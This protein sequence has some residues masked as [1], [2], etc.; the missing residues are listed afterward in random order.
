MITVLQ[1]DRCGNEPASSELADAE[2]TTSDEITDRL[3]RLEI[4]HEGGEHA[5]GVGCKAAVP[6]SES[7]DKQCDDVEGDA[8][9][10]T[11]RTTN[12]RMSNSPT[13][14]DGTEAP[15]VVDVLT[16][17]QHVKDTFIS[18]DDKDEEDTEVEKV[19]AISNCMSALMLESSDLVV[20]DD[21]GQRVDDGMVEIAS[22]S[23]N[24]VTVAEASRHDNEDGD[25][26]RKETGCVSD[27]SSITHTESDDHEQ[28]DVNGGSVALIADCMNNDDHSNQR[29]C[30]AD[31]CDK[32][33]VDGAI[34]T[35][36]AAGADGDDNYFDSSSLLAD[37]MYNGSIFR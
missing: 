28:R 19:S 12:G 15:D 14:S 4:T 5:T 16:D 3:S 11:S 33:D 32:N 7:K 18:N 20:S 9:I 30:I 27:A 13:N 10:D 8:S 2:E 24:D 17:I 26:E 1:I 23:F 22:E 35:G 25:E 6:C 21:Q 36:S 34:V 31:D 37:S 29:D